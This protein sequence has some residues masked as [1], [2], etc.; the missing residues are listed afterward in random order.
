[1]CNLQRLLYASADP[2]FLIWCLGGWADGWCSLFRMGSP[3]DRFT[4]WEAED[5]GYGPYH[6]CTAQSLIHWNPSTGILAR[7]FELTTALAT[8]SPR[9]HP[10]DQTLATDF[11]SANCFTSIPRHMHPIPS[12]SCSSE[13][14]DFQTSESERRIVPRCRNSFCLRE[15]R[16]G[17]ILTHLQVR[18][19]LGTSTCTR[20]ARL[21]P[22]SLSRMPPRIRI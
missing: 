14:G 6:C 10:S 5:V 22:L 11:A 21:P 7:L 18:T 8:S 13:R 20:W 9:L 15:M 1:M 3:N 4:Y 17:L 2:I 19:C 16:D 12:I